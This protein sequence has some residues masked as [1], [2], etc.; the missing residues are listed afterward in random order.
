[1]AV[2][3]AV[4]IAGGLSPRA[5]KSRATIARVVDGRLVH[6]SVPISYPVR[7]GDTVTV[8]ERWF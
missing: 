2:E 6:A 3:T 4:A 1:M 5:A 7:P 8:E